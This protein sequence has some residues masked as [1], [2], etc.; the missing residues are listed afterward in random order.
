[1][2]A[3]H[4]IIDSSLFVAFYREIDSL[5][6]D[7]LRIMQELS[8]AVLVVHPYVIQETA[9]VLTYGSG[10]EVAK[11]FL[12]DT[13]E[14]ANVIVPILDISRDMQLY[15]KCNTKLSFTDVAL[16]GLAKETG[17]RLVTFDKKMLSYARRA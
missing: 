10:I 8:E 2:E 1:M 13:S 12:K 6:S 14:A 15:Q 3:S 11:K 16:V 5:H 9:T 4:C 7:A 17:A